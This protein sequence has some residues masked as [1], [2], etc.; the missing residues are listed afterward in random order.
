MASHP[1]DEEENSRTQ[2]PTY[3]LSNDTLTLSDDVTAATITP[4]DHHDQI[5]GDTYPISDNESND[6]V[7]ITEYKQQSDDGENLLHRES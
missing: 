6:S 7:D 2:S 5:A 4:P 1:V 3:T